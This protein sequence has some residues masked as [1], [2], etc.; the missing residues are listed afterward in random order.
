MSH[1]LYNMTHTHTL[2]HVSPLSHIFSLF[3]LSHFLSDPPVII[4]HFPPQLLCS[5]S[6]SY[7]PL[8]SSQSDIKSSCD[9]TRMWNKNALRRLKVIDGTRK[10]MNRVE[11]TSRGV[12]LD[13]LTPPPKKT[14]SNLITLS[15]WPPP[16][17]LRNCSMGREYVLAFPLKAS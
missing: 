16:D 6:F 7:F 4:F 14:L 3:T 12:V 15:P 2:T 5:L 1:S 17:R 11:I 9:Y 8:S 10:R 13:A